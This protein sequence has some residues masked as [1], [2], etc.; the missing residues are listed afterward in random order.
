MRAE[1]AAKPP[2]AIW[3][4]KQAI[5]YARDHSVDDALQADGLAARRHLEQPACARG[6]H[7]HEAKGVGYLKART[8]QNR[9]FSY[10]FG[11]FSQKFKL[12]IQ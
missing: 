7:G 6:G 12:H 11:I 10:A 1:I 2:V 9:A 8:G 4:T 5:H 3:G